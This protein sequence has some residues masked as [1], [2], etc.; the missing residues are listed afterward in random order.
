MD[1]SGSAG[2]TPL[3]DI[4]YLARST[5]RVAALTRLAEGSHTRR[6]LHE[7]TGISQPTLG[8]LLDGF[9][10]RG[11]ATLDRT[12]DRTYELTPF[13]EVLAAEFDTLRRTVGTMQR[14]RALAPHL[15]LD[16]MEFD[17]RHFADATITFPSAS[18]ATAHL[19]REDEL[20]A[21][22]DSVRFLCSSSYGPGIKAYRDRMVGS[23]VAFEAVI[24]ADALD[25]ATR[26]D[27][28]AEYVHD[29]A[30][31]DNVTIYRYE[32]A[33]SIILGLIDSVVSIVPLD[34]SGVPIAFVESQNEAIR[35]WVEAEFEAHRSAAE[36]VAV[37]RD[38]PSVFTP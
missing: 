2:A 24:T 17:L 23:D 22:A 25:A 8:R 11:W 12:S 20:I 33:L 35:S 4:A 28:S 36:P 14:F 10:D 7:A 1:P 38:R 30:A 6:E 34:E 18:D 16:G 31:A 37:D 19:R 9:E 21:E 26:N 5:N 3:D 27:E 29:L 32:G 13:G 15:P